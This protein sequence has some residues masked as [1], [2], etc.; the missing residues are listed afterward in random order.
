MATLEK[1]RSKSGLLIVVIGV[2]LFAFIIG[3]FINSSTSIFGNRTTIA[4]VDGKEINIMDFQDRAQQLSQQAEQQGYKQEDYAIVQ[5]Q[6]LAQMINETVFNEEIER[7]GITVT[8]EELSA[9]MLGEKALPQ[10]NQIAQQFGLQSAAQLHDLA[11]NPSKYGI[12]GEQAAQL[13]SMWMA[14]EEQVDNMLRSQKLGNLIAGAITANKLDAKA[15]YDENASTVKI[16]YAKKDLSSVEDDKY[17]VSQSEINALWN[18]EKGL[19]KLPEETRLVS[20]ISVAIEPSTDDR[21]AAQQ[22]VEQTIAA[23]RTTPGLDAVANN[24]KYVTETVNLPASKI[25]N[26]QLKNFATEAAIDSVAIVSFLNNEYTIAKLLGRNSEVDSVNVDMIAYQADAAKC[27]SLMAVLNSGANFDEVA[28]TAGVQASQKDTWFSLVGE[29]SPI[30]AKLLEAAT[31][32]YF[33]GDSTQNMAVIYRVNERKAPVTVYEIATAKYSFEASQNTLN[34]L[35]NDLHAFLAAHSTDTAFNSMNAQA[36]GYQLLKTKVTPSSA[37][38]GN[39]IS[40]RAAVKWAMEADKGE[41]SPAFDCKGTIV[42]VAVND[43]YEDFVPAR[44]IDV[45]TKYTMKA[46]NDKKAA[47]LLAQYE[48][49]GQNVNDYAAVMGVAVDTADVTFGQRFVPGIGIDE[50]AIMGN[51]VVAQQGKLVGPLKANNSVIAYEV[52]SVDDQSRPYSYEE[53]AA[54]F[55]RQFGAEAVSYRFN[56]ILLNGKEIENNTLKFYTE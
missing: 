45:Q 18:E 36:A 16:V 54:T 56:Q 12:Q 33:V 29:T 2:A 32:K 6:A 40:S 37:Q 11:F 19:Y 1:I 26:N 15:I 49:K 39:I 53:S 24:V 34:K 41:V 47:D 27:D 3:D 44:D 42:A 9:A 28:K 23:L 21:L 8:D 55:N 22:E 51:A 10:M 13:Q 46:R 20:Y 4:E 43:I 52:I 5:Q 30:K 31:G 38:L 14:Q 35:N 48:G 7:L 17:P 25:T 50:A